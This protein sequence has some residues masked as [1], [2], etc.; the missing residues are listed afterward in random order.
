MSGSTVSDALSRIKAGKSDGSTLISNHFIYAS[1]SL[2]EF[3]SKLF[4][5]MLRHGYVPQCLR[6]CIMQP[7]PKPGKD[8]S[9]SDSY[10][11][12]ALAP[13]LTYLPTLEILNSGY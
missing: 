12:I 7:I 9:D 6:D 13:T 1:S 4:T 10:R 5:A 3:L 8:P 11:P 2:T